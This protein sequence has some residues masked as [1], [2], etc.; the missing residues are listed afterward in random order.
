MHYKLNGCYGLEKAVVELIN[1]RIKYRTH[2]SAHL[3]ND[4]CIVASQ[5]ESDRVILK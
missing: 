4:F 2:N 1:I 5:T 3:Q